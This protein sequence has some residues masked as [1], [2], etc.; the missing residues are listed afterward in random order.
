M[1][2]GLHVALALSAEKARKSLAAEQI[3][4]QK[5]D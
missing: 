1:V 5:E 2:V 4:E 3:E